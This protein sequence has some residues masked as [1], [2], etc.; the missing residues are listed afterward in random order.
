M[1]EVVCPRCHQHLHVSPVD[2][3]TTGSCS[4]CHGHISILDPTLAVPRFEAPPASLAADGGPTALNDIE[5]KI[6]KQ[7]AA[8]QGKIT[9][10]SLQYEMLVRM[11]IDLNQ[12]NALLRFK[13]AE[14]P[15]KPEFAK[16]LEERKV[17]YGKMETF[18]DALIE[19]NMKWR[20]DNVR[21]AVMRLNDPE[22]AQ[23]M[24]LLTKGFEDVTSLSTAGV[25]KAVET[26]KAKLVALG[27]HTSKAGF[28]AH[29]AANG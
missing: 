11:L 3:G 17:W 6:K 13:R 9:R 26:T 28:G 20:F 22:Y 10:G 4:K 7:P 21:D 1:I 12:I 5:R 14:I 8:P 16:E 18:G 27:E 19:S 23:A 25:V 24:H 2:I 15:Q 29:N